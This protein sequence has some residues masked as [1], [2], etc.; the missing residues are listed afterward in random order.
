VPVVR[1]F[2]SIP[3]GVLEMR[4]PPYAVYTLLGSLLWCLGFAGAG[5]AV[6]EGWESFHEKSRYAD[7]VIVA[8]VVL[9]AGYVGFKLWRRR[10]RRR[11]VGVSDRAR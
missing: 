7:Y 2:I 4:F 3:A 1:S 9:A 5:L 8:L 10:V 11:A 6:G